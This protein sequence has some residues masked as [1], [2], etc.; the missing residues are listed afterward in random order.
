MC[1]HL[2]YSIDQGEKA[3]KENKNTQI[4]ERSLQ[5]N[6]DEKVHCSRVAPATLSA[7]KSPQHRTHYYEDYLV[8]V[9]QPSYLLRQP[10]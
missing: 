1:A 6:G 8:L 9:L 5:S 2:H 4:F 10:V 3:I 7:I